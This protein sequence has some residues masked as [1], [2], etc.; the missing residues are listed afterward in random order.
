MSSLLDIEPTDIKHTA[1]FT[2]FYFGVREQQIN[3]LA[4]NSEF[5]VIY[6]PTEHYGWE[7]VHY[8]MFQDQNG[9]AVLER[10]SLEPAEQAHFER[11]MATSKKDT[12][13]TQAVS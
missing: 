12:G 8:R 6:S 9:M 5:K 10:R 4:G 3:S 2:L 13:T 7:Y 11:L 1:D